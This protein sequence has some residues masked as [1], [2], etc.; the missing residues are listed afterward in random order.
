MRTL[1]STRSSYS[2]LNSLLNIP[3]IVT[4]AKEL[5][6]Q[7]VVLADIGVLY[8]D[9][10]FHLECKKQDIK[11]IYG[12]QLFVENEV[13]F[14]LAKN[15]QGF[16]QLM[17]LS[18]LLSVEPLTLE[19]L[20]RY[21]SECIV[22][23][24]TENSSI[25]PLM[26]ADDV[27]ECLKIITALSR[28]FREF[29]VGFSLMESPLFSHKNRQLI[30]YTQQN[31][32]KT[33]ALE[34]AYYL[35]EDDEPMLKIVQAIDLNV[36][37]SDTR[38]SA[39][40]Y[41]YIL[42]YDKRVS[43][44]DDLTNKY[45]DELSELCTVN[46]DEFNTTLPTYQ[47]EYQV[48][49][50]EFLNQLAK[51]G[52]RRRF[53]NEVQTK[54]SE[55]L[56]YELDVIN[57]MGFED[58]FLIV[59]DFILYAKKEDILVG[60]GRGSAAASLVAYSLGITDVDPLAYDLIFER[61][62][63]PERISMPDIDTDFEDSKRDQVIQYVVDK[64]GHDH[65]AHII[66]F[67][68]LSQRQVIRDVGKVLGCNPK[69]IEQMSKSTINR[70][71]TTLQQSLKDSPSL[72][73]LIN[74][75]SDA[76]R[77]FEVALKLEGLPRQRSLHAAGMVMSNDSLDD[78]IPTIY[79]D[80]NLLCT[81]YTM[82][83]LED[84]GLVKMDFLGLKNLSIISEIVDAIKEQNPEFDLKSISMND[85]KT[86]RLLSSGY[87]LGIF[88]LESDGMIA[89]LKQMMPHEFK[90]IFDAIALYRPGPMKN[91]ATYIKNRRDKQ[92]IE[93]I[94]PSVDAILEST[95]GILI[96]QEQVLQIAREFAGF[97]YG[98]ADVLR[99]AITKKDAAGMASM[100]Q[101]FL[102]AQ[103]F[104][105]A[106]KLWALME[107]F[108]EYG[109]NKAHSV[110]YA[111][112]A[113]QMAYL[114]ANYPLLF[115]KALLNSVIG[116]T[117]K[118]KAYT[119]ECRSRQIKLLSP[120]LNF[121]YAQFSLQE[122]GI[123]LCLS[124][125]RSI[126]LH[127]AKVIETIRYEQG[128]FKD[129]FDAVA[130]L[131]KA[132]INQSQIENLIYAGAFDE[133][134]YSRQT[135]I[136]NL[137]EVLKYAEIIKIELDQHT[138]LDYNLAEK[139][140]LT[141]ITDN[142]VDMSRNEANV[143]GFHFSTHPVLS[144]KQSQVALRDNL[145]DAIEVLG[146]YTFYA[147]IVSNKEITTKNRQKMSFVTLEDEWD[148]LEAI[149]FPKEFEKYSKIINTKSVYK[150]SGQTQKN[151]NDQSLSFIIKHLERVA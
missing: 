98:K 76:K 26:L 40:P 21:S 114:K 52:L 148:S 7:S 11:P 73:E 124:M 110:S 2:F 67:S 145:S 31:N 94:H 38:L 83:Q 17:K 57:K 97:S 61:F 14:I 116:S 6:Y 32:F 93:S 28:Y 85:Q 29:R 12:L 106:E 108:A 141:T 50:K 37:L 119:K 44:Y 100:K 70:P 20:S 135:M 66:T 144:I 43:L 121:S 136:V 46:L 49:S 33:V 131:N 96:Y 65:V 128:L 123:R 112:I 129:Y 130:R 92:M 137:P 143:L 59:Y 15:N 10:Q 86:Y 91:R 22:I 55:R 75:R 104:D 1:L 23:Y 3:Q 54:Y 13:F 58:Y 118:L 71:G 69:V 56:N 151:R 8:G 95:Y 63:N 82:E 115:Y 87:T 81:Q 125:I 79:V 90:D 134:N 30:T 80:E 142:N 103:P 64:Y 122:G 16:K 150:V 34:N 105:V 68:T 126:G 84:M 35:K 102:L 5:G 132:K 146:Y 27:S 74:T 39:Q 19:T 4:S 78:V 72:R 51:A 149:L 25:E 36:S 139:P 88:Q 117:S 53:N 47:N 113:Y 147:S 133:F 120:S 111:V 101:E 62:L 89:L 9:N 138:L 77:V 45:T 107:K 127:S 42:E 41:H 18:Q 140:T 109:F 48:N 60:P 24:S 99:R